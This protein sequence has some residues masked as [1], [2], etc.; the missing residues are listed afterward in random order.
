MTKLIFCLSAPTHGEKTGHQVK[1]QFRAFVNLV[2][3]DE[4]FNTKV[5]GERL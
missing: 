3:E 4:F 1:T 5:I 2:V